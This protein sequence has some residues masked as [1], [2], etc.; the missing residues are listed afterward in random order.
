[1]TTP[2][3]LV[4]QLVQL[5]K[6]RTPNF[7]RKFKRLLAQSSSTGDV[8]HALSKIKFLQPVTAAAIQEISAALISHPIK[9]DVLIANGC[10][11]SRLF[12]SK[13]VRSQKRHIDARWVIPCLLKGDTRDWATSQRR[14]YLLSLS[15]H[16]S[17]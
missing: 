13:L 8:L 7:E 2:Q 4:S 17:T 16:L 10:K 9:D 14:Q 6:Q 3:T 12:L 5:H 15:I 1:M 11:R